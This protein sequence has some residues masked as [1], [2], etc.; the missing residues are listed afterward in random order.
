MR[1]DKNGKVVNKDDFLIVDEQV[2]LVCEYKYEDETKSTHYEIIGFDK[3]ENVVFQDHYNAW[4]Y[5]NDNEIEVVT[6]E[7]AV[8]F[9][10]SAK[11]QA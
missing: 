7:E 1:K 11:E 10:H 8:Q 3:N 9:Y 4:D 6:K 2:A 5:Y